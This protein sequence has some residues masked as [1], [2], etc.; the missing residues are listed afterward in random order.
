MF[1]IKNNL[2]KSLLPGLYIALL[3]MTLQVGK[4]ILLFKSGPPKLDFIIGAAICYFLLAGLFA[5]G[6]F[7]FYQVIPGKSRF[8]KAFRYSLFTFVGVNL[9]GLLGVAAFDFQGG[10]NL[11]SAVKMEDYVIA[12]TDFINFLIGGTLIGFFLDKKDYPVVTLVKNKNFI[13]AASVTFVLYPF[14][15]FGLHLLINRFFPYDYQ[16][17]DN[18]VIFHYLTLYGLMFIT[19]L[20]FPVSYQLAAKLFVLLNVNTPLVF[21]LFFFLCFWFMNIAFLL[22]FG[23]SIGTTIKFWVESLVSI[24]FISLVTSRILG[25]L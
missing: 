2:K 21:T 22:P 14:S 13:V 4:G 9:P 12:L 3:G 18:M 23:F 7:V 6:F 8:E 5:F 19:G 1:E 17:P 10:T 11:L 16:I 15:N 24:Y 25:P 20:L